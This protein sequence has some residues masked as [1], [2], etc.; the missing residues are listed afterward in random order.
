MV[1]LGSMLLLHVNLFMPHYVLDELKTKCICNSFATSFLV[2]NYTHKFISVNFYFGL[3][4]VYIEV[5]LFM[6]FRPVD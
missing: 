6:D 4:C 2:H 5:Y 3:P 1:V